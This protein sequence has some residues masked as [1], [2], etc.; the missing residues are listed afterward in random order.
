MIEHGGGGWTARHL[1][2]DYKA[3]LVAARERADLYERT[4]RGIAQRGEWATARAARR[5]L[6][7]AEAALEKAEAA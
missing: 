5:A 4:L 6:K 2:A 1:L 7:K 3:A